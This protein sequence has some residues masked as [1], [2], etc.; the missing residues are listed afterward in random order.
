MLFH[1]LAF[2][3]VPRF[4]HLSAHVLVPEF[5]NLADGVVL[6]RPEERM[7][8]ILTEVVRCQLVSLKKVETESMQSVLSFF[9]LTH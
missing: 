1:H 2:V 6:G 7:A 9:A 5:S 4:G 3:V 8:R